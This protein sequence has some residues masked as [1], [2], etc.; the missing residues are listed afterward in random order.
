VDYHGGERQGGPSGKISMDR[1]GIPQRI[2]AL[3]SYGIH[4][5]ICGGIFDS[6]LI[7][8]RNMGIDVFHNVIGE[9][10]IVLAFILKRKVQSGS[11]CEKRRVKNL[12]GSKRSRVFKA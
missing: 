11:H 12:S 2:E 9:A 3:T 6:S 10:Y 5:L 7:Q 4:K 8:L 1:L